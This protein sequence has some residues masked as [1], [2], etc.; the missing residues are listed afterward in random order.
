VIIR[1]KN[2]TEME[3]KGGGGLFPDFRR[4][5]LG[6]PLNPLLVG[7]GLPAKREHDDVTGLEFF[8]I[9]VLETV[10]IYIMTSP[11]WSLY[12]RKV[13]NG[14]TSMLYF[15]RLEG[16]EK[17]EGEIECLGVGMDP[18]PHRV[19]RVLSF[20]AV[21]R[22]RTP[23]TPHP[24]ASLLP[25]FGS[26]RRATLAG[27]RGGGRVPIPTRDIHCGTLYIY[28]LCDSSRNFLPETAC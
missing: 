17:I 19:G 25:P 10:E 7:S 3:G 4:V 13:E 15:A 5:R 16:D 18:P 9:S 22:I 6:K 26:G 24:Q 11:A 27:E 14:V 28:V 1:T 23:P 12:G 21:V 20:F 2:C 8:L